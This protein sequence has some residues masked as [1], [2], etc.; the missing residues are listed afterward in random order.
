MK[1]LGRLEKIF[2]FFKQFSAVLV[3]FII[4]ADGGYHPLPRKCYENDDL[5]EH[6]HH[7]IKYEHHLNPEL[8]AN[9]VVLVWEI[10]LTY[11][12]KHILFF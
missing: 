7:T 5:F 12:L 1:Q 2:S 9:L 11:A 8:Y 3:K 10:W 6:Y 4:L